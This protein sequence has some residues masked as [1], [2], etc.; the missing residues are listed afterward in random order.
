MGVA[1]G[2]AACDPLDQEQLRTGGGGDGVLG[3]QAGP[4]REVEGRVVAQG[5]PVGH[6]RGQLAPDRAPFPASAGV[7]AWSSARPHS[8]P[9]S[10]ES[11]GP[12]ADEHPV[13]LVALAVV[14]EHRPVG[15]LDHR[16]PGPASHV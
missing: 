3:R 2:Q 6:C 7:P 9:P 12:G 10:P 5:A 16:P 15:Q 13:P 11:V 14:V 8:G 4:G 1:D